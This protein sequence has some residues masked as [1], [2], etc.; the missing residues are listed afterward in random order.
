MMSNVEIRGAERQ[1]GKPKAL[2]FGRP[3]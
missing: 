1:R 3:G 2:A